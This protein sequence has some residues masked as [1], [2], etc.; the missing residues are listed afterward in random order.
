MKIIHVK[1]IFSNL[2]RPRHGLIIPFDGQDIVMGKKEYYDDLPR[3]IGGG[4]NEGEEP[5]TGAVREF[6]EETG[7]D[8]PIKLL[9]EIPVHAIAEDGQ[10]ADTIV[11]CFVSPIT[12]FSPQDDL[13]GLVTIPAT[14]LKDVAQKMLQLP[15]LEFEGKKGPMN[16]QDWG[17]FYG[18]VHNEV[19]DHLVDQSTRSRSLA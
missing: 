5:I 6:K 17:T 11:Y 2:K 18:L 3:F 7:S 1:K 12:A 13:Q 9:C 4:I 10:T 19:Y 16:W 15:D 8:S 14:E